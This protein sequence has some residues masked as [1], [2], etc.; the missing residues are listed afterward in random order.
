MYI[1]NSKHKGIKTGTNIKH[2]TKKL[3]QEV[4]ITL[5][6]YDLFKITGITVY[7]LTNWALWYNPMDLNKV[8]ALI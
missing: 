7:M 2:W 8:N 6:I 1:L 3:L 5:G 4:L